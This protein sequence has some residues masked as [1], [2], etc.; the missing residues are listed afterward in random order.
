[1]AFDF[2][3]FKIADFKFKNN[4]FRTYYEDIT[5]IAD[6]YRKNNFKP[7]TNDDQ[8]QKVEIIKKNIS[9]WGK[10][11]SKI[12]DNSIKK[13]NIY[14]I[15]TFLITLIKK[16]KYTNFNKQ[17][18]SYNLLSKNNNFF[19]FIYLHFLHLIKIIKLR[20]EYIKICNQPDLS[21]DYVF[22]AMHNQP[23]KTTNPEGQE[24]DNQFNAIK[25]L[26]NVLDK[27]I[28]IYV[29]EHPK[30]L[31]PYSADVRQMYSRSIEDYKLINDL[32]NCELININQNTE[33]ILK[34]AKINFTISGTLAWQSLLKQIP[35]MTFSNTWHSTC[36]SSPIVKED[37]LLV[38]K[39]IQELLSK[40]KDEIAS[41]KEYFLKR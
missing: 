29:K 8:T 25:F 12:N 1:M 9:V 40:T 11:G 3:F 35:S 15:L 30:Q 41:D 17:L 19:T 6:D 26:R 32:E 2:I 21:C 24:F 4:F 28:K 39:Q 18:Q 27:K 37:T 22:F 10:I 38:V 13:K 20:R 14:G 7:I 31:N 33:E 23:E 16:I 5:L 34:N 36:K